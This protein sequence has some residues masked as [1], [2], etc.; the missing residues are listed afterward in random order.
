[1]SRAA[2]SLV[3]C[4]CASSAKVPDGC[5]EVPFI[6]ATGHEKLIHS[7]VTN[8]TWHAPAAPPA[9]ADPS[10]YGGA[11]AFKLNGTLMIGAVTHGR[12]WVRDFAPV[13]SRFLSV[14]AAH[15]NGAGYGCTYAAADSRLFGAGCDTPRSTVVADFVG[16][17]GDAVAIVSTNSAQACNA[18]ACSPGTSLGDFVFT[19]LSVDSLTAPDG[20]VVWV[21]T[22]GLDVTPGGGNGTLLFSSDFSTRLAAPVDA[23]VSAPVT[24]FAQL[25]PDLGLSIQMWSPEGQ[26]RLLRFDSA[27]NDAGVSELTLENT[28]PAVA[29]FGSGPLR[30]AWIHYRQ[31]E[32]AQAWT[33]TVDVDAGTVSTPSLVC[34]S[35]GADFIAHM[36]DSTAVVEI[37]GG[38]YLRRVQ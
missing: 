19:N 18:G 32:Q 2:L 1:M 28:C 17:A 16:V 4:A 37:D 14:A 38:L 26:F 29:K 23:M 24:G 27:G 3:V 31:Y 10:N 30:V 35:L 34:D 9:G 36:T 12:V 7:G 33:A 21:L 8:L 6:D 11:L 5:P 13:S 25:A 22:G 15:Q 20:G